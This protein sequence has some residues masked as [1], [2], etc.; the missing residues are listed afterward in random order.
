MGLCALVWNV[1][2]AVFAVESISVKIHSFAGF[3]NRVSCR[4]WGRSRASSRLPSLMLC[5]TTS[6]GRRCP[7]GPTWPPRTS[8]SCFFLLQLPVFAGVGSLCLSCLSLLVLPVF[9]WV[10]SFCSSCRSVLELPLFACLVTSQCLLDGNPHSFP[11]LLLY[12]P[13]VDCKWMSDLPTFRQPV[14]YQLVMQFVTGQWC[15]S[16]PLTNDV[17]ICYWSMSGLSLANDLWNFHWGVICIFFCYRP[18]YELV[19]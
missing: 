13:A 19:K 3:A 18:V 1:S 17:P 5:A 4:H 7:S 16:L 12:Y 11:A 6:C 14:M 8:V 2:S 9:A 10:G 15:T